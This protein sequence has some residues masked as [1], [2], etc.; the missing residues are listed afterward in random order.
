M[1]LKTTYLGL[2]LAHP[3]MAGA[4]PLADQ[5][6][7]V[8]RLEDGGAAAIVLG[9]LFEEQISMEESARIHHMDPLNPEFAGALA[10]FP[11]PTRYLR[12]PDAYLEHVRR[13]KD[14][15][16][17]PVIASLNGVRLG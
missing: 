3:F 10:A 11:P 8:K 9:S 13:V 1:D 15:V 12:S 4:S 6:D 5:L 14:I 16:R 2:S 7:S 17:I